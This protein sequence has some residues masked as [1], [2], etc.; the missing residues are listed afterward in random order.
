M[1]M[2]LLLVLFSVTNALAAEAPGPW[3]RWRGPSDNGSTVQGSYSLKWDAEH[4]RWKTPLPGKGCSTPIVLGR[5][6]FLTAPLE[7]QDAA[8]AFDWEG[9]ELW[10]KSLGPEQA[11]KRQNSSGCNPSPAT[12]GAS[13]FVY[14]KSG[15][16]AAL[17]LE[18]SVRWI[19]NLVNA[20]GPE[21]L[22]W[23][24]GTSPALIRDAVVI[25]RMQHGDSWVAAFDK[26][27]GRIRWKVSRDYETAVEG[28][29]SYTT[30]LV[31]RDGS[32]E[33]V[34]LWGGEHLTAHSAADG[35]VLWSCGD[36]NPQG[37][38]YWPTVA[39][40]VLAGNVVIVPYGRADRDTPRLHGIKLG[41]TG[42]VT[43]THRVWKSQDAGTF[44]PTPVEYKGLVYI[45]TDKGQVQCVDP[46]T[47][48]AV[49]RDAFPKGK[50]SF[51]SSPVIA[52][53]KLYAAREDG[54]VFVAQV[55]GEFKVLAENPLEEQIIA[56]PVPVENRLLIRGEK[57]LF[58]V[59]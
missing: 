19:T 51:F 28:D 9:K 47:G 31:I 35:Q 15:N 58:C 34:L 33:T 27:D 26:T 23:D 38:S 45:V 21:K 25:A 41:G 8:L 37:M 20:F 5:R 29:N 49:W 18:G 36:F 57:H 59:E 55:E 32:K 10:R 24:Q 6:I 4:V 17:D 44:V 2:L 1:R 3:P 50:G 14:Y 43:A 42:D 12:D 53:G 16:L 46:A 30:P 52:A 7:G 39:S 48:K 54:V 22:F 40:P 13:V 56:S 11:G